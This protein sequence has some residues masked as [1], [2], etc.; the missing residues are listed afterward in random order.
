MSNLDPNKIYPEPH[1]EEKAWQS[2]KRWVPKGQDEKEFR[3]LHKE[4]Y[5]LGCKECGPIK[6]HNSSVKLGMKFY[7]IK[8]Q[9]RQIEGSR[10]SGI[11]GKCSSLRNTDGRCGC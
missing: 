1:D 9:V 5:H 10:M 2:A 8:E 3:K 6:E 4:N 7:G 11:C